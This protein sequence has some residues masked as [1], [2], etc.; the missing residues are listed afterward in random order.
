MADA[1]VYL[2]ETGYTCP[3]VNSGTGEDVT[4]RELAEPVMKVVGFTGK[5]VFDSS[6]PDGN[7]RKLTANARISAL[8][9]HP[10]MFL[11]A[12]ISQTY[13]NYVAE[14]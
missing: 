10:R 13:K 9:W 3:L 1:C 6:K 12:C 14:K 5:I 2:M 4:I 8:G 7:A 11:R